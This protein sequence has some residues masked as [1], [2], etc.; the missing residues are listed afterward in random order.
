[1]LTTYE[2][3]ENNGRSFFLGDSPHSMEP[4]TTVDQSLKTTKSFKCALKTFLLA[5]P[6]SFG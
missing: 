5:P 3:K 2:D 4:L 6:H 1:M